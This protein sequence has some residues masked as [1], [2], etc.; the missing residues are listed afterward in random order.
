MSKTYLENENAI[1]SNSNTFVFGTSGTEFVTIAADV[2]GIMLEQNIEK[3]SFPGA[4][5]NYLFAQAGNQIKVFDSTGASL[6]VTIPVQGDL[7]GT[8][9]VFTD[10]AFNGILSNGVMKLGATSLSTTA[11]PIKSGSS[12]SSNIAITGPGI[13]AG[14]PGNVNFT[15]AA[16]NYN[17][18]ITGFHAGDTITFPNNTIY[19]PSVLNDNWTDGNVILQYASQGQVAAITLSGLTNV[20]DRALNEIT[21]F[22]LVFG[23]GTIPTATQTGTTFTLTSNVAS[24][25]AIQEG[26]T[27]TYTITPSSITD[28]AYSMTL[29]TSGDT[30]GGMTPAALAADFS[31]ASATVTFAAGTST[32][33][34]V[35]ETV[36]KNNM[37]DGL[38]GYKTSLFDS[39][40]A[41]IGS[42]T[43]LITDPAPVQIALS[44]SASSVNEGGAVTYTVTLGSASPTGGL[45]IP[46]TLSGTSAPT[47]WIGS[48]TAAG[49]IAVAAGATTGTLTLTTVADNLT[50]GP[51]TLIA[52][53]GTLPTGFTLMPNKGTASTTINDTST[54]PT[55]VQVAL[56]SSTSSVNEGGAVT[57]TVTLGS[58]APTGGLNIPYTLSGTSA[59]TDWTGSATAVGNIAVAA[60]ATTGTLT[61]TTVADNLTEGLETLIVTLGALPTGFTLMQGKG[62]AS[63]TIIDTITAPTQAIYDVTTDFSTTNN[64]NG[65]W[66]LGWTSTPGQSQSLLSKTMSQNGAVGFTDD[67]GGGNIWKNAA[68]Y[69]QFGVAPGEV[70]M[71]PGPTTY[72]DLRWTAPEKAQITITGYFGAGDSGRMSYFIYNNTDSIFQ[73]LN[74]YDN[75]QNFNIIRNVNKGDTIDFLVGGNNNY[76]YGN[77]P[78]HVKI[79]TATAAPSDS[80]TVFNGTSASD[81]FNGTAGNDTLNGNG[82]NDTLN[83]NGGNDTLNGG[84]G[85]DTIDG[86]AGTDVAIFAGSRSQYTVSTDNDTLILTSAAEGIDRVIN[87]ESFQFSD[88][89]VTASS[90]IP[91]PSNRQTFSGRVDTSLEV[92]TYKVSL[93]G[94]KAY[95]VTLAGYDENNPKYGL[96]DPVIKSIVDPS[97]RTLF[98]NINNDN[99]PNPNDSVFSF[100]EQMT[101]TAK[102]SGIYLIGVGASALYG[103]YGTYE[104][105]ILGL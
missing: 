74:T 16:G 30:L 96:Y 24:D 41:S 61:L 69:T 15:V 4:S 2:T 72:T 78:L 1:V 56:S 53:L 33:Q 14:S 85:S 82:G 25:A 18:T 92:D 12:V 8:E 27:I 71:H 94:G 55:P 48:A 80:G 73:A 49:N 59:P 3:V 31:P 100:G 95:Q 5:S 84:S 90:L 57:Y 40:F 103:N 93:T 60:G 101:F 77:T 79:S 20:Q 28:K 11:A 17:H 65:A 105:S 42:I 39:S 81:L 68:S 46:Y 6:L 62:T 66:S 22:N 104:L 75:S 64:P 32:P 51:E 86:G 19:R 34:T 67:I 45:N 50:A 76:S 13:D 83:G 36:V 35:V 9:I 97:N 58:A 26:N 89:A 23:A 21:D 87:V 38:R 98:S 29:N 52:A 88:G 54:A 99:I 43:G 91:P 10:W 70:S 7:N 44:S 63:T 47:D 37:T 102:Q